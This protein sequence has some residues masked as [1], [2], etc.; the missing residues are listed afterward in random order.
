MDVLIRFSWGVCLA[1][2]RNFTG[3]ALY[4]L[5]QERGRS[6]DG[7]SAGRDERES[8]GFDGHTVYAVL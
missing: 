4:S 5:R 3:D 7:E 1:E 6:S 8:T 2:I